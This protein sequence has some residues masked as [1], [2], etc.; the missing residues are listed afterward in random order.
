ML[1]EFLGGFLIYNCAQNKQNSIPYTHDPLLEP[2]TRARIIFMLQ[3]ETSCEAVSISAVFDKAREKKKSFFAIELRR[4][5]CFER[6][7]DL[8]L[9]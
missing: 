3:R 9:V 7:I 4:G 1:A 2:I 6:L 8:K 5:K